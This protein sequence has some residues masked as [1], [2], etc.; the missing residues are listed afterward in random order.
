MIRD[1]IVWVGEFLTDLKN[2]P[3]IISLAVLGVSYASYR[4]VRAKM[5]LD[6]Y[7][8]RFEIYRATIE[9]YQKLLMW[10]VT[11]TPQQDAARSRFKMGMLESH[12]LFSPLSGVFNTLDEFE[13]LSFIVTGNKQTARMPGVGGKMASDM[14]SENTT[15]LV[16]TM[17]DLIK[18]L[19]KQMGSYLNFH[20]A[21]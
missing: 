12:F 17:D 11:G 5:R 20:K 4:A 13:R 16:T 19:R 14:A 9:L 2:W 3:V 6:L 1:F 15:I 21:G 8:R 7:N 10:D 18:K